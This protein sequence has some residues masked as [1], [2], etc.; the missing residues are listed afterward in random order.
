MLKEAVRTKIEELISRVAGLVEGTRGG[1]PRDAQH[2]GSCRGWIT[3]ALNVIELAVPIENNSYPR[4]VRK[5]GEGPGNLIDQ[6]YSIG[7]ILRA[8]LSDIDAGIIADFGNKV[9]AETFDDFLEYA[10]GYR[11]EGQKQ[12]SGV[13]PK[14]RMP[15]PPSLIWT[16]GQAASWRTFPLHAVK[17]SSR[18]P[19]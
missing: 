1:M 9:R 4:Q 19:A 10:D 3:E 12:A 17:T 7:A 18:L 13:K 6:V 11:K 2:V 14:I 15:S 8:L 5:I 16:L